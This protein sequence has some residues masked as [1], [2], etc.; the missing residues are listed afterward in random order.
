[1]GI[2]DKEREGLDFLLYCLVSPGGLVAQFVGDSSGIAAYLDE[3]MTA[4]TKPITAVAGYVFEPQN[5]TKFNDNLRDLLWE[6]K[7][8]YFRASECFSEGGEFAQHRATDV[9]RKVETAMIRL[10]RDYAVYRM[11]RW[12]CYSP[13][14]RRRARPATHITYCANGA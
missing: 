11:R 14:S 8:R 1:M 6:Y 5:Y 3:S 2:P 13:V 10:I 12:S 7:L 9:P 4:E